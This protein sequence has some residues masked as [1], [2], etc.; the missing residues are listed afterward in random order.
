MLRDWVE[1]GWNEGVEVKR[2]VDRPTVDR[3]SP[4]RDTLVHY[5]GAAEH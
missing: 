1:R 3:V 5:A 2:T 4:V